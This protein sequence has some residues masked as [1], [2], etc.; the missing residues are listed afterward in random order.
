MYHR[1]DFE[2]KVSNL[3]AEEVSAAVREHLAPD[4]LSYAVAGDFEGASED[5]SNDASDE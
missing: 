3:T 5:T 2:E 1:A 4:R